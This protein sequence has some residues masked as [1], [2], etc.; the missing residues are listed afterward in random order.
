MEGRGAGAVLEKVLC[1]S[2]RVRR[3]RKGHGIIGCNRAL[4]VAGNLVTGKMRMISLFYSISLSLLFGYWYVRTFNRVGEN[5]AIFPR[6]RGSPVPLKI[7]DLLTSL[8]YDCV[9]ITKVVIFSWATCGWFS[10]SE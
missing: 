8:K 5:H 7:Y 9:N 1:R 6:A 4:L 10:K 3:R 2:L